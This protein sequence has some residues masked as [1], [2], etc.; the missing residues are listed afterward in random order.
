MSGGEG[1]FLRHPPP[2]GLGRRAEGT[3]LPVEHPGHV[4]DAFAK[5]EG[6]DRV[7]LSS[8]FLPG[9]GLSARHL[10]RFSRSRPPLCP[11]ATGLTP[12]GRSARPP[13]TADRQ[14]GASGHLAP[15]Q[16]GGSWLW[17]NPGKPLAPPRGRGCGS[18]AGRACA[19]AVAAA[20]TGRDTDV[21]PAFLHTEAIL[22]DPRGSY[23]GLGTREGN[24]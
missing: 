24:S 7:T 20:R 18:C 10:P 15:R 19:G 8:C 12:R 5:L 16:G 21:A 22:A 2:R 23:N 4:Q 3:H 9:G 11:A 6:N 17:A 1:G 14:A 13:G